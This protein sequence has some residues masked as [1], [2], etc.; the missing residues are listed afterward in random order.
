MCIL[1]AIFWDPSPNAFV[2]PYVDL[3]I[4]WYSIFFAIG[5]LGAYS[6]GVRYLWLD[7]LR[8]TPLL[9]AEQ[10]STPTEFAQKISA[11]DDPAVA[12][13][14]GVPSST[15]LTAC[16][17][18]I[19]E[20]ISTQTFVS[21]TH[22]ATQKQSLKA[23]NRLLLER[24]AEGTFTTA[25]KC[26]LQ[27]TDTL[28]WALFFGLLIGARLGE[29]FFYDFAYYKQHPFEIF[30]IWKG[31]LASH[32]GAI[33]IF[34]AFAFFWNFSKKTLSFLTWQRLADIIAM[35]SAFAAGCI[36]IGNLFNQEIL[37]TPTTLPWGFVFGHPIDPHAIMPCHPVQIYEAVVYFTIFILLITIE[38]KYKGSTP[39]LLLLGLLLLLV[40]LAR[41]AIEWVK[42]PQ[43][44]LSIEGM[45][46]GQL[47]S[48]PFILLG[49]ILLCVSTFR[50]SKT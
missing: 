49:I 7:F 1:S 19:E 44:T 43:E 4:R 41:F 9:T 11:S 42:L 39:P 14:K 36:R 47:L 28:V 17:Q 5:V 32:G 40:F 12:S 10:L 2:I 35:V 21:P 25:R 26:V 15:L 18:W 37:G 8:K 13:L 48:I 34:V 33:G 24:I 6:F 3:A 20:T 50:R 46:M 30:K 16:N 38:K 45:S 23:Q 27:Y 22:F 31:G 29:V